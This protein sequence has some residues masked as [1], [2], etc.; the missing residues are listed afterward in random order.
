[1]KIGDRSH[2]PVKENDPADDQIAG[3]RDE[4][5]QSENETPN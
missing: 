5:N 3:R 1:M 2:L 4:H